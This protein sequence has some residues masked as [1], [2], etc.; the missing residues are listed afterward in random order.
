MV[1]LPG[2][3]TSGETERVLFVGS[4]HARDEAGPLGGGGGVRGLARDPGAGEIE[5]AHRAAE[6]VVLLRHPVRVEGVGGEDV[7]AGFE[8]ARMNV[9]DDLRP[10]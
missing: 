4:Q 6:A 8:E 9:A 3:L 2:S 7:G 10:G 1:R 5:G